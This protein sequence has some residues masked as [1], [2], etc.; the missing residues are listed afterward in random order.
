MKAAI[1][2]ATILLCEALDFME[3]A[4]KVQVNPNTLAQAMQALASSLLQLFGVTPDKLQG[5]LQQAQGQQATQ[6][7]QQAT[8]SAPVGGILSNAAGAQ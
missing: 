8:P 4:G 1:P 2:A 3:K 5:A 7:P 6:Q